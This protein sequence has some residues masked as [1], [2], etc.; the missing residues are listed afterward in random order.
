[1]PH[2]R[3]VDLQLPG[4]N[5]TD[6]VGSIITAD[7]LQAAATKLR[8]HNVR[9]ALP[10]VG[11]DSL[12]NLAARL[13]NVTKL[14]D[15]AG[16]TMRAIFPAYH[17]EGPCLSPDPGY[18]GAHAT[19][20]MKPASRE[21]YEPLIEAAGGFGRVALVTLAPE[22]DRD[23]KATRWLTEHGVLVSL[24]HTNASREQ[25]RDA[26]AAGATL[27][28]HL[29][30]GCAK[31]IDRHDNII[32]RALDTEGL[33]YQFIADGDHLPFFTLKQWV[34]LAGID[35]SIFVT[36]A[37]SPAGAP[38]G[39]YNI[40]GKDFDVTPGRALKFEGTPY[41]AGSTLTMPCAYRNAIEQLGLSEADAIKVCCENPARV[42][43]KWMDL[44]GS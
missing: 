7:Q 32:T 19:Q 41:L 10:M 25:L 13:R 17:I 38:A 15:A 21:L 37:V 39:R 36:D 34:R 42:L 27:F 16:K 8:E 11:T 30:N 31:L 40:W 22:A 1:M 6:F 23:M 26:V 18:S 20:H 5:L 28:T 14:I 43:K 2:P 12:E 4:Y 44:S 29:G 9:A 33:T 35:R 3:Y 24:G